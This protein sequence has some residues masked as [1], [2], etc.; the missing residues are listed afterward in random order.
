MRKVDVWN[1]EESPGKDVEFS[2][3]GLTFKTFRAAIAFNE[4]YS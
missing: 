2:V 1:S 3:A 4:K